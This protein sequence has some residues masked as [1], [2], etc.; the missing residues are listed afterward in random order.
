MRR[1]I[2]HRTQ[3]VNRNELWTN[4]TIWG[5]L[6]EEQKKNCSSEAGNDS[7]VYGNENK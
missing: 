3:A 7:T 6:T 5:L 4:A 1:M 2:K